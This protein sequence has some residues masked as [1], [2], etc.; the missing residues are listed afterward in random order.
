MRGCEL[1]PKLENVTLYDS[2]GGF[3]GSPSKVRWIPW[4][5]SGGGEE[6]QQKQKKG[7]RAEL[8]NNARSLKI[9]HDTHHPFL[10][11]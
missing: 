10:P 6:I 2:R 7:K 1:G 3:S 11:I 4:V 8:N 5:T 9:S